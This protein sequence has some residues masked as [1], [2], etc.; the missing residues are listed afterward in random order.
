MRPWESVPAQPR[1][2]A[3]R[4]FCSGRAQAGVLAKRRRTLRAAGVSGASRGANGRHFER[5]RVSKQPGRQPAGTTGH[6]VADIVLTALAPRVG[7]AAPA[8]PA[9]RRQA[10]LATALADDRDRRCWARAPARE[11]LSPKPNSLAHQ[12]RTRSKTQAGDLRC[13]LGA[14]IDRWQW[15]GKRASA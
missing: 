13:H 15:T 10:S 12:R 5:W 9:E 3:G 8:Q 6:L 4:K 7:Q 11:E 1:G 2:R 14:F